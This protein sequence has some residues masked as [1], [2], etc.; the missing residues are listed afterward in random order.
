MRL[1]KI[2]Q[3]EEKLG[4]CQLGLGVKVL[5]FSVRAQASLE[6]ESCTVLG[7]NKVSIQKAWPRGISLLAKVKIVSKRLYF[8]TV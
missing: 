8:T 7:L 1:Q 2:P 3:L 5:G 4:S 6:L